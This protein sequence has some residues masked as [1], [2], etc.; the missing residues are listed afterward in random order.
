MQAVRAWFP[1]AGGNRGVTPPIFFGLAKENGLR[2][3]QKKN[4]LAA[5]LD[6]CVKLTAERE[7]L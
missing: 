4:A 1:P 6:T 7:L 3:V 5:H 2:P